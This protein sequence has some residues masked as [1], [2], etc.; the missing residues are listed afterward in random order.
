MICCFRLLC[1]YFI[2][3]SVFFF[4]G[5]YM[6]RF[7]RMVCMFWMGICF[8]SRWCSMLVMCCV[9]MVFCVLV[10]RFGYLVVMCFMIYCVFC[11]LM[12]RCVCLCS[13]CMMWLVIICLVWVV[14]LGV[15]FS[16]VCNGLGRLDIDILFLDIVIGWLGMLCISI[17]YVFL[18]CV[19]FF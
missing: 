18:G 5:L 4:F 14:V 3:I 12:N 1:M 6:I 8:F 17:L 13:I 11:R 19:V 15:V 7:L 16:C 10:I 9:G 2:S